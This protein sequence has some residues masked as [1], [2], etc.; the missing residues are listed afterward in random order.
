MKKI[1]KYIPEILFAASFFLLWWYLQATQE[2]TFY[3]REQEQLFLF[4]WS[5]IIDRYSIP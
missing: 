5:A 1:G 4:D 2:F 3:N